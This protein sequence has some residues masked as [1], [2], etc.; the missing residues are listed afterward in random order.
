V[1]IPRLRKDPKW[2]PAFTL[3]LEQNET[4]EDRE[5]PLVISVVQ[6]E[7]GKLVTTETLDRT[8]A[9]NESLFVEM[10]WLRPHVVTIRIG[11]S[12]VHEINIPWSIDSVGVTASTGEL[13][14]D[15]LVL[16][17]PSK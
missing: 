3:W 2:S 7:D 17:G 14:I 8:L 12:E 11:D 15:P 13:I 5:P 10:T 16:G 6:G 9:L 1:R 4:V